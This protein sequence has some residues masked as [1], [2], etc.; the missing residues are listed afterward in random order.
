MRGHRT[1]RIDPGDVRLGVAAV[2]LIAVLALGV[3]LAGDVEAWLRGLDVPLWFRV[4][5]FGGVVAAVGALLGHINQLQERD[6]PP[7]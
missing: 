3:A 4:V 1:R 7:E 6:A 2:V 5:W